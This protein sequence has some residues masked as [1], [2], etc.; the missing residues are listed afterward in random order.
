MSEFSALPIIDIAPLVSGHDSEG[1]ERV[2]R[3]IGDACKRVGFFY[4]TGR[5][6][7]PCMQAAV[8][9]PLEDVAA[10]SLLMQCACTCTT[11]AGH[12]VS[13]ELQAK[14][15]EL[16]A[17]FFELPED[18]KRKVHMSL[19]GKA[20]RGY[21]SSGE[22]LTKGKPDIK[23]GLYFGA[24]LPQE[25]PMVAAG[26]PMHGQNLFPE[27]PEELQPVVLEYIDAMIQASTC[28]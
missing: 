17:L 21:F 13:E 24:E 12:G 22:E 3:Q 4:I 7:W 15:H 23:E 28:V 18:I 6:P 25:H 26:E 19:G 5:C 14:L 9:L 27:S 20:W 1:A 2:A 16:S 8:N 10:P 11:S